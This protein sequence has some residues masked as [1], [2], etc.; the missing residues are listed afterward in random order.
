MS[1]SFLQWLSSVGSFPKIVP[2]TPQA[3]LAPESTRFSFTRRQLNDLST[4]L[5]IS[6]VPQIQLSDHI[7]IKMLDLN[8]L[9]KRASSNLRE[10]G[11]GCLPAVLVLSHLRYYPP[12]NSGY[13]PIQALPF[14]SRQLCQFCTPQQP[15]FPTFPYASDSRL[16]R[17]GP[18]LSACSHL[19]TT[20]PCKHSRKSL[21][22]L[23][24][25]A[26]SSSTMLPKT[27]STDTNPTKCSI[28]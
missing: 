28:E 25:S 8:K 15:P 13:P 20:V 10:G 18:L 2:S 27:W 17:R 6:Q 1:Q 24:T 9:A 12:L 19:E 14:C 7:L 11:R 3:L 26:P 23:P 21:L 5:S 4:L 16:R 22:S